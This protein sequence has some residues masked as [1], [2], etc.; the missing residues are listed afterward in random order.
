MFNTVGSVAITTV[1]M[2]SQ[3]FWNVTP[4]I[5]GRVGSTRISFLHRLNTKIK[6]VA[7]SETSKT[8][9]P[10]T[11]RHIPYDVSSYLLSSKSL[12]HQTIHGQNTMLDGIHCLRDTQF[13][14]TLQIPSSAKQKHNLSCLTHRTEGYGLA[15]SKGQNGIG[16]ILLI[17]PEKVRASNE[18]AYD[19]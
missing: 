11:R 1:V 9:G 6:A 7:S 12:R 18:N 10:A 16:C 4:C 8:T 14:E 19:K 17:L 15:R 3:S 13:R 2:E 5:V